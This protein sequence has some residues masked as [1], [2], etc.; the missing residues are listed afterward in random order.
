[1][2][3]DVN[4]TRLWFDVD[5]PALEPAGEAM[6]ARP[7]LVLVHGG[8]ATWDHSYL[9]PWFGVLTSV[10][11]VV[12]LDL[13][14][15]GRSAREDTAGWTFEACAD[16][17][18]G[19]CDALGIEAPVVLGHSLGGM[20]AG[21]YGARHPGHAAGLVL[22][23]TMG[24]FDLDRL[25]EGFR[26]VAGDEVAALARR[27]YSIDDLRPDEG[28]RVFGAFGPHVPSPTERSR[29]VV[30]RELGPVG[31]RL[32]TSFDASAALRAVASPTLVCVGDLDPVTPVAASEELV[33]LLPSGLGRLEVIAGA[34][35]F[36]W[37]DR[38]AALWPILEAFVG[39]VGDARRQTAAATPP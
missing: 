20:I 33:E 7:T 38:P 26:R 21:L 25:T 12:Y 3:I 18:R 27:D 28:A 23:S 11:Q 17:I 29:T 13:R 19:F 10:A 2:H 32:L 9:K 30:N 35:H 6:R 34:G 39:E 36:P 15:H 22:L 4:G 8:P 31:S 1:M 14:N 24:R 37:L 16:D 5:G